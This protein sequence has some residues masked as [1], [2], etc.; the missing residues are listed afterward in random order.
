[1]KQQLGGDAN[2]PLR[3]DINRGQRGEKEKWG[4]V[5]LRTPR[6]DAQAQGRSDARAYICSSPT[7]SG[8]TQEAP[9]LSVR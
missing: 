3:G 1:M 9:A 2:D 4:E 5:G 7:A 6:T 8:P